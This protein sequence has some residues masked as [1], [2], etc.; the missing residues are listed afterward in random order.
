MSDAATSTPPP[1]DVRPESIREIASGVFII[2]DHRV[3]LVPNIGIVLGKDA[4]LVVDTGMGPRNG[5]RVLEAARNVAGERKLILTLTHFHPEHGFGAQ[6]FKGKADI[7]YNRA[8]RE[9]LQR[10]GEAYVGMFKAFGPGV[11]AALDGVGIVMPDRVY[12]G[13]SHTIDLGGRS[14]EMRTFGLAH[15]AGDQVVWLPAER[16][17]FVGDLAEERMFPIFP[18]FPPDD[19]DIDAANWTK[20]LGEVASWQ[21]KTVVPGHGDVGGVGILNDLRSYMID[22]AQRVAAERKKGVDAEAIVA[23]LSQKVR[24]THPGW[25]SPEWIDFA[26]RYYATLS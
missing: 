17:V 9:E 19:A 20:I 22:L 14:V 16:I 21:P 1:P 7:V 5:A 26:I 6:A 2:P 11:A 13:T 3:P 4:A 12:D 10:K 24:A 23:A 25:T 15:T 18:W 8:Q